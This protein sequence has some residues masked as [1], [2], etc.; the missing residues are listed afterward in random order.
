MSGG[1]QRWWRAG[2]VSAALVAGLKWAAGGCQWEQALVDAHARF[3]AATKE[4]SIWFCGAD[5]SYFP[6][7]V[8]RPA[9]AAYVAA[10]G[11]WGGASGGYDPLRRA[12]AT[13][14]RTAA[15]ECRLYAV[16]GAVVWSEK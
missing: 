14:T 5:D 8:I 4:L 1:L 15:S 16:D 12:M 2:P 7:A 13:C 3:G 10:S 6:P 11:A 9:H